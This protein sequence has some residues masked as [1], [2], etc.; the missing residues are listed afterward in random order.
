MAACPEQVREARAPI[1]E[2]AC[3]LRSGDALDARGVAH[4]TRLL[5]DGSGPC[6]AEGQ[7]SLVS[8]LEE[9]SEWLEAL[10]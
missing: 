4:L 1:L 2:L 10:D 8:A 9:V 3:R 7:Q 6:Y 5:C